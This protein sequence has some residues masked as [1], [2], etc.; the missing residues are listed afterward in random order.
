MLGRPTDKES[1]KLMLF[2]YLAPL[3]KPSSDVITHAVHF[4][5]Q[6]RGSVLPVSE[7][8]EGERGKEASA[9]G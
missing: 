2:Y 8:K 4:W 6:G 3:T 5:G 1:S 7:K 9:L